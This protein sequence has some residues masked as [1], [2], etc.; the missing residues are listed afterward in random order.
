[1]RLLSFL[2]FLG[3]TS[4]AFGQQTPSFQATIN[5]A[6]Q[7]CNATEIH[8][9]HY[10]NDADYRHNFDVRKVQLDAM[11]ATANNI[12][13]RLNCPSP[14]IIPVAVH[15]EGVTSQTAACL[16]QLALSQIQV[17][18]ED[19]SASNVDISNF[20]SDVDNSNLDPNA[21]AYGGACI[22]F[23][24][25]TQNHPSGFG[26]SNGDY[27]IT[28][29]QNYVANNSFPNFTLGVWSGYLNI[30]VTEGTGVLGYAPLFGSGNGD[31]VVIEACAFGLQG[32]GCG[33]GIGPGAGCASYSVYNLGRTATHEVGHYLGLN[34]IWGDGGC[35]QDDGFA[36]TPTSGNEYYGCPAQG[37]NSCGSDDMYM[38][39]MDYVNDACMYMFSEQQ[40]N[41][42]YQTAG[43]IWSTTSNKCSSTPSYPL[44]TLPSGCNPA[45]N[46]AG[47]IAHISP[48]ANSS[49]CAVGNTVTPEVTI[50]NFGA[51]NLTSVTISYEINAGAPVTFNWNGNLATGATA[52][53]ILPSYTEPAGVYTFESYT[54][55]PNNTADDDA[56]NDGITTNHQ[57]VQTQLLPYQE[58]FEDAS[59]NPTNS[60]LFVINPDGDAFAWAQ[61]N[62]SANGT[63]NYSAFF[64]NYDEDGAGNNPGGTIDAIATPVFNFTN[65]TGAQ[66]T[67][68]V[69]YAQY[70]ATYT[71][72]L[73]VL[74]STD[75]GN[76]YDQAVFTE[77]S[78][79]LATVADQTA[80]FTPTAA[81][82]NN[83]TVDLSAYDGATDVSIAFVNFSG[84]GNNLYIDNININSP[85]APTC[86]VQANATQE[87]CAG[88]DG[89]ATAT[90][91]G[92]A[93]YSYVWSNSMTGMQITGLSAGTYTV[94]MTDNDGCTATATAT[95]TDGCVVPGV[96]C[97]TLSNV[98]ST[99]TP[100]LYTSDN[101]GY[102]SGINGYGDIAKADY[103]N[104][105]G[106]NTSIKGTYLTFG[107][108]TAATPGATFNVTVWEGTGGTPG[109]S[110]YSY[111][112]PYADAV[113]NSLQFIE[114]PNSVA[115]PA[116][117]EFFVG[118][119][120]AGSG[121]DTV[122]IL[123]NVD[124]EM[125]P[126]TGTAWEQWNDNS[127]YNYNDA[128]SWSLDVAH[129]IYPVL[130]I[131]PTASF[132]PTN[133]TSCTGET[134]TYNS[135]STDATSYYWEFPG[136]SPAS[137]TSANPTVTYGAAGSY[138]VTFIA[139]N[140]CMQDSITM[141]N[142]VNVIDLS[143]TTTATDATCAGNDGTATV[144]A[145][146]GTNYSYSWSN[147]GTSASI[148]SLTPGTYTVTV[149]ETNTGCMTT[150]TATV[151]D[152]CNC[153]S[154]SASA[155]VVNNVSCFDECDGIIDAIGNGGNTPYSYLWSNGTTTSTASN[156][157][158]GTYTVTVTDND[159]CTAT[160]ETAITEPALIDF[161][162]ASTP[163][164]CAGNDG[165]AVVSS[166][167]IAI[168]T[169]A[170]SNGVNGPSNPNI[171]AG[172]YTVTVTDINTQCSATQTVI[173]TNDC[174]C[175]GSLNY[176]GNV[177]NESCVGTCDGS[178]NG[179]TTG[180]TPPYSYAWNNGMNM[181]SISNVCPGDYSVTVT[182]A[183]NCTFTASFSIG[184][185]QPINFTTST[186]PETCAGDDGTATATGS[187]NLTYS[188][189]TGMSGNTI[190]GLS[191]GIYTVTATDPNSC[192]ATETVT[193][194]E[195][196]GCNL[197]IEATASTPSCPGECDATATVSSNATNVIYQWSNGMTGNTIMNLCAGTY[198]VTATDDNSCVETTSILVEDPQSM[199]LITNGND[200]NCGEGTGSVSVNVIGGTSPFQYTW[201]T[202]DTN[203]FVTG[204]DGGAYS[205]TVMDAS[206]CMATSTVTIG[207]ASAMNLSG[208]TMNVSCNGESDGSIDV[209]ISGGTPP[210]TFD[211]NNGGTSEDL[212]NLP[213]GSYVLLVTDANNC[214]T[215]TAFNISEPSPM[216]TT[217]T[218]IGASNGSNGSATANTTGGTPPYTWQWSNG[219]TGILN[220]NLTPGD[221][222]VV[223][224]DANG[225]TST[226]VA[227]VD[228]LTSTFDPD[229][230]LNWSVTPNP[231]NGLF[232]F[233]MEL[234][235]SEEISIKVVNVLGQ[236]VKQTHYN[237]SQLSE[238]LDLQQFA[239]GAYFLEIR[240]DN[241]RVV[242][243]L[244]VVK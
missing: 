187:G 170:W 155:N 235:Q 190:T 42:M 188:W 15:Y 137:S 47:V 92:N 76:L 142:V 17:L 220:N 116:S 152:G 73:V 44:A 179:N 4:F 82:W 74:V 115:V 35:A 78:S 169:Y 184:A 101:S 38:N 148:S 67:F 2:L 85:I 201:N 29:N 12:E 162:T 93:P 126:G 14:I 160:A 240:I 213:A 63:G 30:F 83:I 108:I 183:N 23:C 138:N 36:D 59:F 150:A 234:A 125:T 182:D 94:T 8:E 21:L 176:T 225:C 114:F 172:T 186:T 111:P 53:A 22:Q 228:D 132:M 102:V 199:N 109:A 151:A 202:G 27:A 163:E 106:T 211:W 88:N 64:N 11:T 87:S 119:E 216:V 95:V 128:S 124:G 141:M 72:T 90:A 65:V 175:D 127:W 75:C 19:Y 61:A 214:S 243:K 205:V 89:T 237:A 104:Y 195:D 118:I 69:A 157:C 121:A 147:G 143:A 145:N 91:T 208:V 173:V 25:A 233:N 84:W 192:T 80:A 6:P 194:I 26:L 185:A 217:T 32:N 241:S 218:T 144:S 161:T 180:G 193:V 206:G 86:S 57:T 16:E 40:V 99:D 209:T 200:A 97:D 130:G 177:S 41:L 174:G 48:V 215:G 238:T 168:Y 139:Y 159:G 103:F 1:M 222:N 156:L 5:N 167:G 37:T 129:L 96:G 62:V 13:E 52:N 227:S 18:N 79:G 224:T 134:I 153:G 244:M 165:S 203:N 71:D 230:V 166:V 24:L 236:V 66:L 77:G 149:T 107:T 33:N 207:Q 196:C 232:Q 60:G 68:D 242:E 198:T 100:N 31:G 219:V 123:T 28:T 133:T 70:D 54:S 226:A 146:G 98:S 158:A 49:S 10:A 131:Q 204:L 45:N 112:M 189:S 212:D 181:E 9:H 122:T 140:D 55:N 51:A 164:T 56:T 34:H 178:I 210:Y 105:T 136:G 46:D 39:Y 231:S 229:V 3:I 239:Q 223:V 113:A 120:F 191:A 43:N 81:D 135:T 221:Y 154:L 20:C 50:Q 58:D 171:P 117:N 7:R 197:V 110:L